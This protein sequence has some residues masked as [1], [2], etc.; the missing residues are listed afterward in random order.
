MDYDD[1]IDCLE[2]YGVVFGPLIQQELPVRGIPGE[3]DSLAGTQML[4]G[5]FVVDC[6]ADAGYNIQ[7]NS[8]LL[9]LSFL[10]SGGVRME[11]SNV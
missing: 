10:M 8:Y 5:S 4:W 3:V 6:A 1:F 11:I 9:G 2:F 7:V